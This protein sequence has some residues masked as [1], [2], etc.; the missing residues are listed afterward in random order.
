MFK[1]RSD[2]LPA[3]E[4]TQMPNPS[5]DVLASIKADIL[6]LR[7]RIKADIFIFRRGIQLSFAEV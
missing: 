7:L 4:S 5:Y 6:A 1:C 2:T 3:I